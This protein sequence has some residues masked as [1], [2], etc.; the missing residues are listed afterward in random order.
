MTVSALRS[1][2]DS[3]ALRRSLRLPKFSPSPR[4]M[5]KTGG[6]AGG[7]GTLG[8]VGQPYALAQWRF[9][10]DTDPNDQLSPELK[11]QITQQRRQ[12]FE[13]MIFN[14]YVRQGNGVIDWYQ[15]ADIVD[16]IAQNTPSDKAFRE[17]LW[18]LFGWREGHVRA[19]LTKYLDPDNRGLP[20]KLHNTGTRSEQMHH[21]LGGVTGNAWQDRIPS[22]LK[23]NRIY[24]FFYEF[25]DFVKRGNFNWGDVRLFN[26]AEKHRNDFLKHGR[27]V[28]G[29]N[30]RS[31]LEPQT[32]PPTP[33]MPLA[34]TQA[35][36]PSIGLAKS[37]S[38]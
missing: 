8:Y 17:D 18:Y 29:R 13:N 23:N 10:Q 30:I 32:P 6:L 25:R 9:F 11:T 4:M 24:A 21:Y 19:P 35:L 22:H 27:F 34:M 7:L 15:M 20:V 5:M 37:A 12:N 16:Y 3:S 33:T 2:F 36:S 14:R 1:A 28:V 38:I 26:V 31:M